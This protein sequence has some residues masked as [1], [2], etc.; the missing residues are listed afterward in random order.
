MMWTEFIQLMI[1][2]WECELE[3]IFYAKQTAVLMDTFNTIKSQL[4]F[5][6]S[7]SCI[8]HSTDFRRHV[9]AKSEKY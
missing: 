1:G 7:N 9:Q 5:K 4:F 3:R 8:L 2:A 6:Y